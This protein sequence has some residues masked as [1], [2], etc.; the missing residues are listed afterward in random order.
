MLKYIHTC[1]QAYIHNTYIHSCMHTYIYTYMH[2]YIHA[3]MHA[4]MHACIT[5]YTNL[6]STTLHAADNLAS[7]ETGFELS[8]L[9]GLRGVATYRNT[10]VGYYP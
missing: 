10:C 5:T 7:C 8:E 4:C 2:A 1:I 9:P 6:L 3:C